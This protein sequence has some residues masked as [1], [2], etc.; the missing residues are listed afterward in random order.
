MELFLNYCLEIL[1][2]R[3]NSIEQIN[4]KFGLEIDIRDYNNDLVLSHDYP[5]DQ[6]ISLSNYLKNISSSQ[7]LAINIKSSEIENDL[8]TILEKYK[9]YNYFTFDWPVPSLMKA[10][11]KN[12]SCAFRLSEF[13][14]DIVSNCKWVW[15]DSFQKIW[16]DSEFLESLKKSGL[17]IA[18]VSP[19]LHGRKSDLEQIK[20]IVSS[21]NVD[22]I[23]TDLPDF[24]LND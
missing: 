3:A 15:I 2:H 11:K 8:F 4:P 6:C 14:K 7:L 21:I 17:K 12:L 16:Y 13:E 24:W 10:L 20:E 1:K 19:E 22:A 18:L 9:I 5:T 23:C